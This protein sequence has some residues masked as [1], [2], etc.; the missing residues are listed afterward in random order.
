MIG[1]G[2]RFQC[3][4]QLEKRDALAKT[5]GCHAAAGRHEAA[6]NRFLSVGQRLEHR[7]QF[8]NAVRSHV[9]DKFHMASHWNIYFFGVD[10]KDGHFWTGITNQPSSGIDVERGADDGKDICFRNGFCGL[11]EIGDGLA[12]PHNPRAQQ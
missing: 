7:L 11:F 10:E 9:A 1:Q 5:R 12:K 6:A 4:L 2:L 3:H 8:F